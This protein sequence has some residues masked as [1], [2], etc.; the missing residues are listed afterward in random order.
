MTKFEEKNA[1]A[2]SVVA[3]SDSISKLANFLGDIRTI[4]VFVVGLAAAAYYLG[5]TVTDYSTRFKAQEDSTSNLNSQFNSLRE[6]V[7]GLKTLQIDA[8]SGV[9]T[10]QNNP[11][12]QISEEV[13]YASLSGMAGGNTYTDTLCPVGSYLAGIRTAGSSGSTKYCIGCLVSV[14]AVCR[15]LPGNQ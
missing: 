7:N 9:Q 14:Q 13:T 11:A 2:S 1:P 5:G 3:A 15:K 8:G 4:F 6:E 12:P 10:P